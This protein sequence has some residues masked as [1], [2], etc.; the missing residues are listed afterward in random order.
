MF[1]EQAARGVASQLAASGMKLHW[2]SP[3]QILRPRSQKQPVHSPQS[4]EVRS[5][6]QSWVMAA[7]PHLQFPALQHS[8][9]R[10]QVPPQQVLGVGPNMQGAP[11]A[12][13][14]SPGQTLEVPVH[15]SG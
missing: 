3:M 4:A 1:Q 8:Q 2:L 9:P 14:T 10:W 5:R 6:L 12:R 7:G 11:S 15:S 13:S